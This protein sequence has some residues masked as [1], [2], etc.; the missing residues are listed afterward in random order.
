MPFPDVDTPHVLVDRDIVERNIEKYQKYCS[1][2]DLNLRPHI[3]T[4]KIPEFAKMQ[5][6]AGCTSIICQKI[7]E[8]EV[9]ADTGIDDILIT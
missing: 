6:T 8:A 5:I 1:A 4:H 3:K 7:G 9:M 2:H